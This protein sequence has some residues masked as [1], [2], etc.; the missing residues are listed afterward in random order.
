MALRLAFW[1]DSRCISMRH[2]ILDIAAQCKEVNVDQLRQAFDAG[3]ARATMMTSYQDHRENV[4]GS[5]HFFLAD[6]TDIHNPGIRMHQEGSPGA[7]FLVVD[8]D[9]PG[10]YDDLVRKAAEA[11]GVS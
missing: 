2:E 11:A 3:T 1:R 8:A 4:Q 6:G 10:V 9:D 7:G 5:P